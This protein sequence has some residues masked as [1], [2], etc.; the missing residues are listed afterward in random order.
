MCVLKCGVSS[1]IRAVSSATC[2]SGEPVSLALRALVLTISA[3]LMLVIGVSCVAERPCA[4]VWPGGSGFLVLNLRNA[5]ETDQRRA[6]LGFDPHGPTCEGQSPRIIA[7]A[8]PAPDA[9]AAR[10]R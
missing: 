8:R 6:C 9:A 3:L 1:L 5:G 7:E 4:L 2:T 10:P